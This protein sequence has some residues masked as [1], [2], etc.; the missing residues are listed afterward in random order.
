[1]NAEAAINSMHKRYRRSLKFF[2][3]AEPDCMQTRIMAPFAAMFFSV[4]PAF[5]APM[6]NGYWTGTSMSRTVD[7]QA[8]DTQWRIAANDDDDKQS[9]LTPEQKMAKRYPQ[10]VRV[11]FLLGLPVLD[12]NSSIIGHVQAVVRTPEGKIQL[13]M[14]LGGFLGIGTRLVPIP[15]EIVGMLGAQ[16]AVIDMPADRFM[17]SPTWTSSRA[18]PLDPGE[19]IRVAITRR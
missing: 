5:A 3:I 14:P 1:M 17:S 19:T 2:S 9:E 18:K 16:V 12:E 13:V 4:M 11:S 10:P 8:T 15:I 7:E 6:T